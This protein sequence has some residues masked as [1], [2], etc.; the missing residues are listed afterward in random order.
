MNYNHNMHI[1]MV[2]E[3]QNVEYCTIDYTRQL[4][5]TNIKRM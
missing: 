1:E 3:Y 2:I 4:K 5:Y